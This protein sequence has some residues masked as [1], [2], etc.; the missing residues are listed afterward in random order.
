MKTFLFHLLI[1]S[2]ACYGCNRGGD[3]AAKRGGQADDAA[4][5][6]Q[7]GPSNAGKD[8]SAEMVIVDA[9]LTFW[10]DDGI[11]LCMLLQAP[12]VKVLGVTTTS[13]NVSTEQATVNA[14]RLLEV[15]ERPDVGVHPGTPLEAHA[16][17][18]RYY[19]NVERDKWA[20]G[21]Y[22][23]ALGVEIEQ[24][25]KIEE[26]PGGMPRLRPSELP[27][28]DFIIEQA[29]KFPG[30]VTLLLFG[31]ATNLAA[32]L[33]KEPGLTNHLARVLFFGGAINQPGNTTQAAE[34]NFWFDPES[35]DAVLKAGLPLT[36][37]PLDATEGEY[38]D[39][40]LPKYFDHGGTAVTRYLKQYFENRLSRRGGRP[41]PIWDEALVGVFLDPSIIRSERQEFVRVNVER[42]PEYGAAR[43]VGKVKTG[44]A[45][46]VK[47][48]DRI[49][50]KGLHDLIYSLFPT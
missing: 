16:E 36:L 47:V 45:R 28:P 18:L 21:A 38:F 20:K 19:R 10:G 44:E 3:E 27:A 15:I 42:G 33:R 11:S 34:F 1:M 8:L 30:K 29:H 7:A 17:R 9:D 24:P 46:P 25:P 35:A 13:G 48:I 49:D 43:A 31:P 12:S 26:P 5:V 41:I 39:E 37:L 50:V 2:A 32:A 40:G 4:R 6:A 14:L 23:G 22:S